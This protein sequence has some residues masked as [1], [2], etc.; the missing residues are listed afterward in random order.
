VHLKSFCHQDDLDN[1]SPS[2]NTD[3]GKLKRQIPILESWI[4]AR[5]QE[6][7]PLVVL[8]DFNRRFNI[9]GD[10]MWADLDDGDP[11]LTKHTEG[12]A[13]ACLNSRFP[14]YID[15]IV[16]DTRGTALVTPGSFEQLLFTAVGGGDELSDHCPIA[17]VFESDD[18][19]ESND[20]ITVLLNRL[21]AVQ[22]E[23]EEIRAGIAALRE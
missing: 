5:A 18:T 7:V 8:G 13:S 1:V 21:D 19:I 15:Y 6:G 3:C 12:L 14:D 23:L 9:A 11:D 22:A 20:A 4:E 10:D 2:D 16:T 17:V